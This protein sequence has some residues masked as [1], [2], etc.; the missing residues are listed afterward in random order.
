MKVLFPSCAV[1][2]IIGF[3]SV[4]SPNIWVFMASRV[5]TGFFTPGVGVQMFV[6]ASE[7]VGNKHRPLAGIILW[8]FFAIALTILGVKAYFIRKWK[9]LFIV[10]TAPYIF[11]LGF[12]K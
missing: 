11:V 3:L 10:C 2:I 1:L 4:F 6:M 5:V 7:F 8:L 9:L 12:A